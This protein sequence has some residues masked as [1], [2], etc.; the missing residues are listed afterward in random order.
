MGGRPLPLYHNSPAVKSVSQEVNQHVNQQLYK[1]VFHEL[2]VIGSQL[3][4][5]QQHAAV[6]LQAHYR[7]HV[8]RQKLVSGM[9]VYLS[10]SL[11]ETMV[12]AA[13]WSAPIG[14]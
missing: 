4:R 10:P 7:G 12:S 8:H 6:T 9:H 11:V 13:V 1:L 5:Q 3:L 2:Y 14:V